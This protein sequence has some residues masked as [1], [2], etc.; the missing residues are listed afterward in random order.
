MKTADTRKFVAMVASLCANL[1]QDETNAFPDEL[2]TE[3]I[4][5]AKRGGAE[6]MR[7][8]RNGARVHVVGNHEIDC[9]ADPFVPD[10]LE[11]E[12]D[13]HKKGG[14]LKWD[15]AR[16][17]LH[18]STNQRGG[19]VIQGHKLRK[20]LESEPVLNAKVL[21]YLLAHT[22]LIPEEWK[23]VGAIFFWGTIY[24]D[25]DG[26]LCVRYLCWYGKQWISHYYWLDCDWSG[27]NPALLS[28]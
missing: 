4:R 26:K 19:K 20:E 9:D 22:E 18:L 5:D 24:R 28:A 15:P 1:P 14:T 25:A 27:S 7:F 10:G 13:G 11:V 23:K 8:L 3:M 16:L 21:D 17:R 2:A 12:K 6:L